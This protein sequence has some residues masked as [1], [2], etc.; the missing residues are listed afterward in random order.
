M[1]FR[2]AANFFE[3]GI[4]IPFSVKVK[5]LG[6]FMEQ[7]L[8]WAP[9]VKEVSRKMFAAVG[10][11]RRLRNF[12]PLATK[13]ALAILVKLSRFLL[14]EE[15]IAEELTE[16]Q[17][18]RRETRDVFM[19]RTPPDREFS[20]TLRL[21]PELFEALYAEV[22]P[23]LPP[24]LN[25]RGID[26]TIKILTALKFYGRGDYQGG[27]RR[28]DWV[29]MSQQTVSR[30]LGEVTQALNNA[31]IV[32]RHVR[33]PQ[34]RQP[35]RLLRDGGKRPDGATLVPW[36]LGRTLVWDATCVD[37]LAA[38]HIQSTALRAGAAAEQAQINKRRKYSALTNYH[39]FAALA[40]ET[41]G[42]WSEDTKKFIK[43]L[44]TRLVLASGDPRAGTYLSQRLGITVQRGF[45][46]M[47]SFTVKLVICDDNNY[48]L[49]VDASYGGAT[50]DSFIW[51]YSELRKHFEV[52]AAQMK[53]PP[54]WECKQKRQLLNDD[55]RIAILHL[56]V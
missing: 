49:N 9:Q 36:T 22:V 27:V 15:A 4:L 31:A 40:F 23:S 13:I 25:S 6:V 54:Y 2:K 3:N 19:P 11:L 37:T 8:A 18:E 45:L 1:Y 14:V 34:N 43:D 44:S 16:R 56:T 53:E 52:Y 41:M 21:T 10:S 30:C 5:N 42:P 50:H 28:D 46:T 32:R 12:L 35:C 33:F 48:I 7:S 26:P 55:V 20:N 47:F 38:S 29:P 17:R 51:H 39:E 24:K